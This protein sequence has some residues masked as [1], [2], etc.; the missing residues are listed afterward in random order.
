MLRSLC[1]YLSWTSWKQGV[2]RNIYNLWLLSMFFSCLQQLPLQKKRAHLL[3]VQSRNLS[4]FPLLHVVFVTLY[5]L[6]PSAVLVLTAFVLFLSH[7]AWGCAPSSH[8]QSSAWTWLSGWGLSIWLPAFLFS[9]LL[10]LRLLF[11]SLFVFFA[12]SSQHHFKPQPPG[13][14]WCLLCLLMQGRDGS[15][16]RS[17]TSLRL[18]LSGFLML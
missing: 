1:R 5:A 4:P 16:W 18:S 8:R 17:C 11:S 14:P 6:R 13:G 2:S 7:L 10:L 9:V 15:D 12:V 3:L